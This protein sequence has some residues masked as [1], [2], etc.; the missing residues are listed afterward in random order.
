MN[1][2]N[3]WRAYYIDRGLDKKAIKAYSEYIKTLLENNVPPIFEFKHLS[4]LLGIN[5]EYLAKMISSP[6]NFYRKFKIAKR[7]GGRRLIQSP[8]PSLLHCQ[9]WILKNIL[10]H[11][12]LHDD[13][14]GFRAG[15]GIKTN[16]EIHIGSRSFLNVDLKDF[17]HQIPI[18]WVLNIFKELGYADNV[19]Y[20]L[21]ALSCKDGSLAQGAAT[22][23]ALSNIALRNLDKRLSL[24]SENFELKYTRYADDITFSGKFIS[25]NF[26][27]TTKKIIE[28]Y[29]LKINEDKIKV[30]NGVKSSS[31]TGLRVSKEKISITREMKRKIK[32]EVFFIENFG[33]TSHLNARKIINPNYIYSLLG[34]INFWLHIEPNN[35]TAKNAYIKISKLTNN[36]D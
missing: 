8:Y 16:A 33:L 28:D 17:F 11:V 25:R 6:D 34:R 10:D 35:M 30:L 3:N 9:R 4:E 18:S 32:N 36:K 2:L 20:Y 7:N 1:T 12:I 15:R 29:G 26:I 13:C 21:S 22:S 24:I 14:H 5:E 19:A 27:D 31:V 23:P